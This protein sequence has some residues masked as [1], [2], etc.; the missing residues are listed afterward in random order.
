MEPQTCQDCKTPAPQTESQYTL[1]GNKF[2]WR[3]MRR[4]TA[5]GWRVEWRCADCWRAFKKA[6]PNASSGPIAAAKPDAPPAPGG[7][8]PPRR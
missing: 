6:A 8:R 3:V 7:S 5:D 1:I 4:K 2:G